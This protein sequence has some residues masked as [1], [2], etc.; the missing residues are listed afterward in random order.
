M[1]MKWFF[2]DSMFSQIS[3][4]HPDICSLVLRIRMAF[5]TK[6][7][8]DGDI[9]KNILRF[10]SPSSLMRFKFTN[11]SV[12]RLNILSSKVSGAYTPPFGVVVLIF[13]SSDS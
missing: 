9:L 2:N 3:Y 10:Y 11:V 1:S 4:Y 6:Y 7:Y 13:V 12:R 8:Y 5:T